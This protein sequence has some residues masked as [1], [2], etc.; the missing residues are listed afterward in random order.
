MDPWFQCHAQKPSSPTISLWEGWI[1]VTSS[2]G[3]IAAGQKVESSTSI[4][5]T[6]C[7]T[8][9]LPMPMCCTNTTLPAPSIR[10]SETFVCSWRRSSSATTAVVGGL[11]GRG[12][13]WRLYRF[14]I[15]QWS[16]SHLMPPVATDTGVPGVRISMGSVLTH[17][18]S[19][20]SVLCL[21]AI[22]ASHLLT[23][24]FSGTKT[25]TYSSSNNIII[26]IVPCKKMNV[27][28]VSLCAAT[29][30]FDYQK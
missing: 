21:F 18:G 23:A 15:F 2:E 11:V 1:E 26:C 8:W 7:L 27:S 9:L 19:A 3:I 24:F 17:S 25:W 6:F 4:Y 14:A 20:K 29:H 12:P 28:R 30:L 5:F 10:P 13:S 22:P 16:S